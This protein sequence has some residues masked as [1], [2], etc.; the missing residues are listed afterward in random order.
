[1][2]LKFDE[3]AACRRIF[4]AVTRQ[5]DL[6]RKLE[7][8]SAAI[9]N[10]KKR[11]KVTLGLVLAAAEVTGESVE[12]FLYGRPGSGSRGLSEQVAALSKATSD[13]AQKT[14][15]LVGKL[16]G[17]AGADDTKNTRMLLRLYEDRSAALEEW[18]RLLDARVTDLERTR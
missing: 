17:P 1:M 4:E 7:L 14:S 11:Q 13:V 8:T 16:K 5:V 15:R 6:A 12:W 10:L 2:S 18:V 3:A 9:S